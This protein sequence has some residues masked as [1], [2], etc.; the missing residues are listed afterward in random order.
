MR[1]STE[2]TWATLADGT[3]LVTA[4]RRGKGLVVLFHVTADTRW[5]DLPLSGTFVEM[6]KRIVSLSGSIAADDSQRQRRAA[7]EV[8]PPTPRSRRLR[9]VRSAAADRT[10]GADRLRRPRHLRSSAG[11]LRT[12]G[13]AC[14][15]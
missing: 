2:R 15:R 3:P 6:L 4:Q 10:A 14:W 12:A 5:S 11:I 9:R 1:R 8:V 13:R 7:R